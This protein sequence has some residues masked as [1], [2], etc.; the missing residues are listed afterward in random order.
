MKFDDSVNK[1]SDLKQGMILQGQVTNVT[2]FGAFVDVGVHQDG[3]VHV[4]QLADQYVAN[5]ADVVTVG[6][7]VRVKVM[8]IDEA[9]KRIG[10]SIKEA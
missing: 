6:D 9:R 10:L 4:S 5:P 7:V 1:M 3:L 8:E 2:N